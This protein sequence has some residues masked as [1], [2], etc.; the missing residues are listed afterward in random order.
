MRIKIQKA[1][2]GNLKKIQEL[3]LL[4]FKE[5]SKWDKSIDM[6]WT[7]GGKGACY[8]KMAISKESSCLFVAYLN[9]IILGYLAAS[10]VE[11]EGYRQPLKVSEIEAVF[12]LPEYRGKG[13]GSLLYCAFEI[14]SRE[15]GADKLKVQATFENR[16]A[17][18]FYQ[19]MGLIRDT[20][21]LEN[22]LN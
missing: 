14:W 19:R 9:D 16:V 2:I 15:R 17:I 3:S 4:L 7:Y 5:E 22:T 1:T 21:I 18:R 12:V 8:F 20:V 11:S 10:E 6:E 13:A